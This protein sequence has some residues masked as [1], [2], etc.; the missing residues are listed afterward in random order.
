MNAGLRHQAPDHDPASYWT[1]HCVDVLS[2]AAISFY[3]IAEDGL[4]YE[5]LRRPVLTR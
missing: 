5:A 4:N 1:A 3:E 2:E